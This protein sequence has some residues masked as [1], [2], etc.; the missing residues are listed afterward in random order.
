MGC[1]SNQIKNDNNHTV[2]CRKNTSED[3][4]APVDTSSNDQNKEGIEAHNIKRLDNEEMPN[5]DIVE[6]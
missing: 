4:V 6:C 5:T 1:N 3:M 2:N